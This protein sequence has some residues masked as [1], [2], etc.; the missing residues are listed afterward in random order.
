MEPDAALV[1]RMQTYNS[2]YN[3]FTNRTASA[4]K[5]MEIMFKEVVLIGVSIIANPLSLLN[6][7]CM[8]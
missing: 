3:Q 2:V 8:V 1:N 4:L 7:S 6:G 5:E